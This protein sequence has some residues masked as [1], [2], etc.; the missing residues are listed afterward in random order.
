MHVCGVPWSEVHASPTL[1]CALPAGGGD[2]AAAAGVLQRLLFLG[3]SIGAGLGVVMG[4]CQQQ[5]ASLFTKDPLV[6]EQ[7]GMPWGRCIGVMEQVGMPW[8]DVV[9]EHGAG[10]QSRWGCPGGKV[11]G[12]ALE[13]SEG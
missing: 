10:A 11:L 9:A 5:V 12:D 7:V 4:C 3:V 13:R 2:R 8:G 6:M 1:V